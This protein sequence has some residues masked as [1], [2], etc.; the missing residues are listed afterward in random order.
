MKNIH[1]FNVSTSGSSASLWLNNLI[2][3]MGNTSFH[4]LRSDPFSTEAQT[5]NRTDISSQSP[6]QV[7]KGLRL[8]GCA[9]LG[10]SP[11]SEYDSS[12]GR[13]TLG[14]VH[15]FYTSSEVKEVF[16][17][18]GGGRNLAIFR[19]PVH[20]INSQFQA[21]Y[22]GMITRQWRKEFH[23]LLQQNDNCFYSTLDY[24]VG[25]HDDVKAET[26]AIFD[27]FLNK[28]I[29]SDVDNQNACNEQ[30]SLFYEDMFKDIDG[31]MEKLGYLL[32]QS[33][34]EIPFDAFT[35]KKNQHVVNPKNKLDTWSDFPK[36]LK[37]RISHVVIPKERYVEAYR[38]LNYNVEEMGL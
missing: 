3:E 9:A 27:L 34:R 11:Q 13:M 10:M 30:E 36:I 20:R 37:D 35:Q 23:T 7:F 25:K 17:Q 26:T 21:S 16:K 24:F 2:N 38:Q 12:F 1:L 32:D 22:I 19:N 28:I 4:G 8:L 33:I 15:N 6:E 14:V 5:R 31:T 29:E 18:M